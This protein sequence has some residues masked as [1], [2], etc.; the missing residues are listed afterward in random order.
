MVCTAGSIAGQKVR[1]YSQAGRRLWA[2]LGSVALAACFC[3]HNSE[4]RGEA[5]IRCPGCEHPKQPVAGSAEL[6][7]CCS[8]AFCSFKMLGC[9]V[10]RGW[11]CWQPR[12]HRSAPS[13]APQHNDPSGVGWKHAEQRLVGC[14][15]ERDASWGVKGTP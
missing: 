12:W 7:S 9:M 15:R 11:G 5:L 10:P 4:T 13:A 8:L 6:G 2:P 14:N 1:L 3:C